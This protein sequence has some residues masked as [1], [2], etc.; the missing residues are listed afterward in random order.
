M[1]E[2]PAFT[3]VNIQAA[4]LAAWDGRWDQAVSGYRQWT[5]QQPDHPKAL[6]YLAHSL[7]EK[8][9]LQRSLHYFELAWRRSPQESVI[10]ERIALIYEQQGKNQESQS[11]YQKAADLFEQKGNTVRTAECLQHILQQNPQDRAALDRLSNLSQNSDI[12]LSDLSRLVEDQNGKTSAGQGQDY[13]KAQAPL[14]KAYEAAQSHL[15][16]LFFEFAATLQ[17]SKPEAQTTAPDGVRDLSTDPECLALLGHINRAVEYLARGMENWCLTE[18]Q[19]LLQGGINNP[20]IHFLIGSI[21][22]EDKVIQAIS[23]LKQT[24]SFPDYALAAFLLL[25][26]IY[27][28]EENYPDAAAAY[29]QALAVADSSASSPDLLHTQSGMFKPFIQSYSKEKNP[30]FLKNLCETIEQEVNCPNWHDRLAGLHSQIASGQSGSTLLAELLAAGGSPLVERFTDVKE[31]EKENHTRSAMEEIF[32]MIEDGPVLLPAQIL[33]A[34]SLAK[35]GRTEEAVEKFKLIATLYNLRGQTEQ[36]VQTLEQGV[37]AAPL[38]E[39]IR[40][41]LVEMLKRQG[42]IKPAVEQLCQLSEIFFQSAEPARAHQ[43]LTEAINMTLPFPAHRALS[44]SLLHQKAS[45]HIQE[46]QF[47][48][49]VLVYEKILAMDPLDIVAS[50]R[51]A[52]LHYRMGNRDASRQKM[53]NFVVFLMGSQKTDRVE[54]YLKGLADELP[55]AMEIRKTLADW[56]HKRGNKAQAIEQLD[57]ILEQLTKKGKYDAAL[58]VLKTILALNPPDLVKYKQAYNQLTGRS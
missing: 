51:T 47:Q 8:G 36:A 19:S 56:Y 30:A 58:T 7:L 18:L 37:Q 57:I 15:A 29:L 35:Q 1:T 43:V 20:A 32:Y 49:A 11:F 3:P 23:H 50:V 24:R 27:Y 44:I 39:S 10:A 34:E 16:A 25:G 53:N 55:D 48:Q 38:D 52:T 22:S 28:A 12:V 5:E 21:L 40:T 46:V 33:I 26:K 45:L 14:E 9:D 42:K 2:N 6:Q 13:Q 54:L 17:M 41:K 4:H 31:L